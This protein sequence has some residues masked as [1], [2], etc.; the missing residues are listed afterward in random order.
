MSWLQQV[1]GRLRIER[2]WEMLVD[3]LAL[4]VSLCAL[5]VSVWSAYSSQG[6]KKEARRSADA[7][8]T[9]VK[10]RRYAWSVRQPKDGEYI[11]RNTGTVGALNV[12]FETGAYQ[13]KVLRDEEPLNIRSGEAV[14][15]VAH[16]VY[17]KPVIDIK[18]SWNPADDEAVTLEWMEPA[19]ALEWT[20]PSWSERSSILRALT[21]GKR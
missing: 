20:A 14:A 3:W 16:G 6:S 15:L 13:Q 1:R 5:A 8:E 4:V 17:Q 11:V 2:F 19:P 18:I 10:E 7:A 21:R 9:T 12:V